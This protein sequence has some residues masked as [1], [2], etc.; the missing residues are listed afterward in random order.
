MSIKKIF[1]YG[2]LYWIL[3]FVEVSIIGFIPL[4]ASMGENGFEFNSTGNIV[5]FLAI[6]L[7]AAFLGMSY[8]KKEKKVELLDAVKAFAA[9][10]VIGLALD[11]IVTVPLFVKS[12][13]SFY[14]NSSLWLSIVFALIA[15]TYGATKKTKSTK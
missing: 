9:I 13:S 14:G 12:Y 11:A 3:I 5:Y 6:I 7:T 2:I 1:Q 15:F 4:F 8:F 10:A